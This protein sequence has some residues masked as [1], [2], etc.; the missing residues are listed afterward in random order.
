LLTPW[1]R[2]FGGGNVYL[3]GWVRSPSLLYNTVSQ[4]VQPT[5]TEG[6]RIEV[7]EAQAHGRPVICSAGAGA[8]ELASLAIPARDSEGL[9][10]AIHAAMQ[11]PLGLSSVAHLTWPRIRERYKQLWRE[12]LA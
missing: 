10:A 2:Q 8:A 11:V 1:V 3:R 4:Y 7:L 6:F 9:A 12:V 5:A